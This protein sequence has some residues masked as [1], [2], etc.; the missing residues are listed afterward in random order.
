MASK[1]VIQ[2]HFQGNPRRILRFFDQQ[3]T[4]FLAKPSKYRNKKTL[5]NLHSY[6]ARPAATNPPTFQLLR[7]GLHFGVRLETSPAELVQSSD[8]RLIKDHRK[9]NNYI[10]KIAKHV[11]HMKDQLQRKVRKVQESWHVL[12]SLAPHQCRK[13][14][15]G[16]LLSGWKF[17]LSPLETTK[18]VFEYIALYPYPPKGWQKSSDLF[19]FA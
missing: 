3:V 18:H 17:S 4:N 9:H 15:S 12:T 13:R 10:P 6:A 1:E 19:G 8:L 7:P 2:G 16:S 11:K 5:G 14:A